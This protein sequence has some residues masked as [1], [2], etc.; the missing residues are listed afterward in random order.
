MP[1]KP[2]TRILLT[3][4]DADDRSVFSDAF[5][6][7][8]MSGELFMFSDGTQLMDYLRSCESAPGLLFLDLNMPMK[9]GFECIEE[10]RADERFSEIQ[11]AV[12]STSSSE[13]DIDST[14]RKGANLY[15]KKPND[16]NKLKTIIN[17]VLKTDWSQ[18]LGFS[19]ENFLL[20]I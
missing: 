14:F 8:K 11:I 13:K 7:L 3:D 6:E 2:S 1:N 9:S 15:I 12:Y 18:R 10:I 4:D 17:T 20:N 5:A 16:Y 19:K